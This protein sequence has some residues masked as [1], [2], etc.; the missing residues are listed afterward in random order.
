MRKNLTTRQFIFLRLAEILKRKDPHAVSDYLYF[1]S[2]ILKIKFGKKTPL[3][4]SAD[5]INVCNLKCVHCY[6]W[7]NRK[8]AEELPAEKWREIA[9]NV[10]KKNHI[11]EITLVGGEPLL[12]P[13][14]IEVFTQELPHKCKIVTNATRPLKNFEGMAGY[15]VSIDGTED[16]HNQI[17]LP[18]GKA[19]AKERGLKSVPTPR[20]F[21]NVYRKTKTNIESF[22]RENGGEKIQIAMTVNTL[23]YKTVEDVVREW[24]YNVESIAFQFHTPFMLDDHLWLPFGEERNVLIDKIIQL[25]DEFPGFILNN[26]K[27]LEMMKRNWANAKGTFS[28]E[29]PTWAILALDHLGRVKRPCCI[30]SAEPSAIKPI[31]EKCGM[32]PYSFLHSFGLRG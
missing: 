6:W 11:F 5:I 32:S 9:R 30:G 27:Q 18:L 23:N 4:G 19:L 13:D 3:F 28:G 12:R 14:V 25:R 10:F 31:C 26:E 16:V 15:W 7:L 22:S 21:E 8:V 29:C 1:A 20:D 17:R 2:K 24:A